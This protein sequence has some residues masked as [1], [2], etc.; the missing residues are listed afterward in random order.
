MWFF[1]LRFLGNVR[2]TIV[3]PLVRRLS[4]K[5]CFFDFP[6]K[7]LPKTHP[8]RGPNPSKIDAE[9]VLFFN[10]DFWRFRPRN[11]SLL[12]FQDGAKLASKSIFQVARC[13]FCSRLKIHVF[14]KLRLRGL[15]GRFWRPLASILEGLGSICS[16]FWSFLGRQYGAK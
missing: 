7:N 12:G 15:R 11:W 13:F 16:R 2:F 1:D 9:N 4:Q 8:K 5:S 10:I 3:K 14:K 6:P